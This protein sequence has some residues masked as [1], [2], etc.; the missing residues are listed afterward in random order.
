MSNPKDKQKRLRRKKGTDK[1]V[2]KR[3]AIIRNS[4]REDPEECF[5]DSPDGRLRKY[6]LV[7]GCP[8]CSSYRIKH[9]RKGFSK[10]MY[11]FLQRGF[12]L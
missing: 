2:A 8:S 7:C 5:P 3:K 12:N 6:N 11:K 9:K 1:I 10:R 4:W